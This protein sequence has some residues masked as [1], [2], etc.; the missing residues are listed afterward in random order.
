V[1]IWPPEVAE[2]ALTLENLRRQYFNNVNR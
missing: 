2:T 1:S